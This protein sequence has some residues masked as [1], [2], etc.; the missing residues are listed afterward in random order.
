MCAVNAPSIFGASVDATAAGL[1]FT[2]PTGRR[3]LTD[4]PDATSRITPTLWP[5]STP[6]TY[7]AATRARGL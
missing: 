4:A 1:T 3:S 6:T 2:T 5:R 7:T